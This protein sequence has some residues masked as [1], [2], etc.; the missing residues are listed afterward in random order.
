MVCHC[1]IPC[2]IRQL[3]FSWFL[4][5]V[6]LKTLEMLCLL[7][8]SNY[9]RKYDTI[10]LRIWFSFTFLWYVSIK[11][12]YHLNIITLQLRL[13]VIV[14]YFY[15]VTITYYYYVIYLFK[16]IHFWW[17]RNYL[18]L[19]KLLKR[20]NCVCKSRYKMFI[21]SWSLFFLTHQPSH[22]VDIFDYVKITFIVVCLH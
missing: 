5:S 4:K 12:F 6:F 3:H 19:W 15:Y 14:I 2:I 17:S 10:T 21:F 13:F 11:Y 9:E 1:E 20:V 8:S 16:G 18:K 7:E 22:E